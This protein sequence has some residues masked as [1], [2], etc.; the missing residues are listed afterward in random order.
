MTTPTDH[1]TLSATFKHKLMDWLLEQIKDN[2]KGKIAVT[3]VEV[4][5]L[6][7]VNV[8]VIYEQIRNGALKAQR[9]GKEWNI[10][11]MHLFEWLENADTNELLNGV[12]RR[13]QRR[14]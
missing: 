1:P 10:Y 12:S 9:P 8:E 14:R 3:A 4:S 11:V 7:G 13:K 6:V 2:C 5:K